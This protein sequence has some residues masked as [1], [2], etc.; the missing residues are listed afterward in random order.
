M[1]KTIGLFCVG[2]A[3]ALWI[4]SIY[5]GEP[6]GVHRTERPNG[7]LAALRSDVDPTFTALE[8][9]LTEI[10]SAIRERSA[11]AAASTVI[12]TN[13]ETARRAQSE[14]M[15]SDLRRQVDASQA[16]VNTLPGI[17]ER[18]ALLN[19][20]FLPQQIDWIRQI[21]GEI[22]MQGMQALYNAEFAGKPVLPSEIFEIGPRADR[23]VR[24]AMADDAEFERYLQA[25]G[26]STS[27]RVAGVSAN[28]PAARA[29]L[30]AKD[31]ILAY[32]GKR[33]F[34]VADLNALTVQGPAGQSIAVDV[35]RDGQTLQLVLP[36]GP[37]AD[38]AI[39]D[40]PLCD[41]VLTP[42]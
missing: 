20:G 3:A 27:L 33:V 35:R 24:E 12:D 40:Q 19:A 42:C 21:R 25:L 23:R 5:R 31:E 36:R 8:Q 11:S 38:V 13:V 37:I 30:R 7:D 29:G 14:R 15:L 26:R 16:R 17:R 39:P 10:E 18:N 4:V 41:G 1:L 2:A 32:D 28:S 9:R 34:T 22:Q 6:P